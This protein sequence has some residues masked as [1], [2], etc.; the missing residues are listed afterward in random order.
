MNPG[1]VEEVGQSTRSAI[2]ALSST[3][4][5][6]AILIF[7]IVWMGIIAYT[8]HENGDRWERT[9]ERTIKSCVPTQPPSPSP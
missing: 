6:L 7:N 2:G 9:I 8:S 4:V 5:V 1:A 3:P